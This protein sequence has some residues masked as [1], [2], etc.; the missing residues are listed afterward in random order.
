MKVYFNI[1]EYMELGLSINPPIHKEQMFFYN[2]YW[3]VN[4]PIY[5]FSS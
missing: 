1:D 2:L 4:H 5:L 3:S